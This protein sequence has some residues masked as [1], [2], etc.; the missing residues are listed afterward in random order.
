METLKRCTSLLLKIETTPNSTPVL[1]TQGN[2]PVATAL[3]IAAHRGH[4][5]GHDTFCGGQGWTTGGEKFYV[6]YKILEKS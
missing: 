1:T 5:C 3:A 4:R 2:P 6:V